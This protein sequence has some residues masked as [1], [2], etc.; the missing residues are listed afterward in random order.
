[1]KIHI[2]RPNDEVDVLLLKNKEESTFSFVNLTK[3]HICPCKFNSIEEALQDLETYKNKGKI[4]K[5][6]ICKNN[7][8]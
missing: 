7:Y 2:I 8:L 4:I 6:V 5:W 1:M 3:C